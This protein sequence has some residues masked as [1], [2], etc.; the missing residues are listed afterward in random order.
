MRTVAL[1]ADSLYTTAPGGVL[2]YMGTKVF[3]H[4][5][6]ARKKYGR[7]PQSNKYLA[8]IRVTIGNCFD[9][10]AATLLL[11]EVVQHL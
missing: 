10:F 7:T 2:D 5:S 11:E 6:T 1:C 8:G 9:E 4:V 3:V